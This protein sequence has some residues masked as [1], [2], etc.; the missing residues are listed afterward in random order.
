M[1]PQWILIGVLILGVYFFFIK[2]K[3]LSSNKQTDKKEATKDGD[4]MVACKKCGTY[5]SLDE[6]LVSSGDYYCSDECLKA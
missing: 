4:E 3:P 1:S 5:I 2:K 6:A